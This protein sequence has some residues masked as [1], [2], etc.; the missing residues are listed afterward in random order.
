M[1]TPLVTITALAATLAVSGSA[2]AAD[3]YA[4]PDGDAP[5]A[6]CALADPCSLSNAAEFAVKVMGNHTF[7]NADFIL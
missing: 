6:V 2:S 3:R 7:A 5:P 4:A 1:R